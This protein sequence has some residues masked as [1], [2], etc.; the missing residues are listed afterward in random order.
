MA[1]PVNPFPAIGGAGEPQLISQGWPGVP[2]E[3]DAAMAGRIYISGYTPRSSLAK[4]V[5]SKLRSGKR[6]G[7]RRWRGRG[8][9]LGSQN[10][11][12]RSRS[13]WQSLFSD[14]DSGLGD[15]Y[16][17]YETDWLV[18]STCEPIQS[19][20]FFSGGGSPCHSCSW[21]S[22]GRLRCPWVP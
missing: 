21:S 7:S 20:Y 10:R 17:N 5:K 19:V 12:Q 4:K 14:E 9:G 1:H 15:N 16:D 3:V 8:R 13:L 18:P 2:G 6:Y 22:W 11:K